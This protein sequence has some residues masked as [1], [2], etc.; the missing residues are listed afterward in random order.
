MSNPP[1]KI[2]Y[3]S[4]AQFGRERGYISG[5]KVQNIKNNHIDLELEVCGKLEILI[6]EIKTLYLNNVKNS[7][8]NKLE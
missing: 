1:K 6:K 5:P 2:S 7:S 8:D 4:L 3:K